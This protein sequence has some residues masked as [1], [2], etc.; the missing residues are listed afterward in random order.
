MSTNVCLVNSIRNKSSSQDAIEVIVSS[1]QK[2]GAIVFH[3]HVTASNQDNIDKLSKKD[4]V[5]FHKSILTSIRL[6]DVIVSECSNESFS[7]GFLLSYAVENDK[8][9]IIFIKKDVPKPNLFK[10]LA[11]RDNIF[12]IEYSS[13]EELNELSVE[14]LKFAI[15]NTDSRFNFYLPPNVSNY[16]RWVSKKHHASKSAFVRDMLQEMM[17]KDLEYLH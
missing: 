5:S 17:S 9:L 4:N 2:K 12:I 3:E 10:T 11:E 1:L 6:C 13:L 16:L 7:V 15:E 8:P 14:Y